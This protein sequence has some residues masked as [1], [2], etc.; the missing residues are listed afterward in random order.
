M[1]ILYVDDDDD[2]VFVLKSRL[3]RAGFTLVIAT[4]GAQGVAMAASEQPDLILMDLSLP[5]LDGLGSYAPDQSSDGDEAYPGHRVD[6]ACDDRRSGEGARGGLQR[7][8]YQA[9]GAEA[10]AW[11]DPRACTRRQRVVNP[12]EAALLVVDDNEDNRYTLTRRLKSRGIYES[13]D[14]DQWGAKHWN[15][16][17]KSRSTSFCSIS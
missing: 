15:F 11:Q 10:F 2:N 13:D 8:R 4:D 12:A 9:G 6:R 14:R 5:I 16:C 1:K 17:K 3:S 7:F